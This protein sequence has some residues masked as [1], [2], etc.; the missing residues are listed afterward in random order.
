[1]VRLLRVLRNYLFFRVQSADLQGND[2][3]ERSYQDV[4]CSVANDKAGCVNKGHVFM[5]YSERGVAGVIAE[6][7]NWLVAG[8][9]WEIYPPEA[10][11][12]TLPRCTATMSDQTAQLDLRTSENS[13]TRPV[14]RFIRIEI[15]T[16]H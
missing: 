15:P 11:G 16:V 2:F 13:P 6:M 9:S 10:S 3:T 12:I 7:T 5:K 14:V 1:M 4:H 8:S